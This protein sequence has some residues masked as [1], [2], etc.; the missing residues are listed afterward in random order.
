MMRT[1]KMVFTNFSKAKHSEAL[2][3]RPDNE[4][5]LINHFAI[6]KPASIL[7][8]GSGLSYSDSNLCNE[9]LIIDTSRLNH[10]IEFDPGTAIAVCQGGASIK[11]LF[12]F[13]PEF[14]PPVI[15]GT[16]HATVAGGIAHDVHGKNNHHAGSFG[17]HVLWFDL[18][19][20][21]KVYHCS[22][23][24]NKELFLA[25]IG[26]LGL[27]GII[28]RVGLQLKN[29][30]RCVQ[31][32]NKQFDSIKSLTETMSTY[33][34]NY[35]YQVAWLDLLH[36]GPRS[37]LSFANHSASFTYKEE[38][39]HTVSKFP[40]G[41]IK[42]WNMKLF[43][44]FYFNSKK[45]TE[46]LPLEQFNNPLDKMQHWNRLYGPK[47][48]IQFQAVF[49]QEHAH[50]TI[51]HLVQIIRSNQATPTLTVLK[52]FIQPGDGLLSFCRAGFTIAIDFI[53]NTHAQ[54]AI[55]A[56]NQFITEL[57]GRIYLAKDLLLTPE[58]FRNMYP[59]HEQWSQIIKRYQS[60]MQ[61]E[62]AKRLRITE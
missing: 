40:F 8:R 30:S 9:G 16:V 35:N 5:D 58:Q 12:L 48:L 24:E 14:I 49:N 26:G 55:T 32:E 53:H 25:T 38:K 45:P 60:P 47:G 10:L 54:K 37:L 57:N 19:I 7:A 62:L 56:M 51:E 39:S 3:L 59:H 21:D 52:L 42:Q 28:L 46:Q 1:P 15:P 13:H 50:S 34:L 17:H 29:A 18:L 31:V 22:R 6:N 2:C 61:S 11:D 33:G 36:Q 4:R 43:N 27:T 44:T 23:E 20:R 41:L